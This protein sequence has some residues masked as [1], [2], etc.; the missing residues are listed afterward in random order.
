MKTNNGLTGQRRATIRA[1]CLRRS[2]AHVD[3]RGNYAL[4]YRG[5]IYAHG[6]AMSGEWDY[7]PLG[8]EKARGT[9]TRTP[10]CFKRM[11]KAATYN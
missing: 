8:S 10:D 7:L 3:N 5:R 11:G 6:N 1:R 4:I 9:W 2:V